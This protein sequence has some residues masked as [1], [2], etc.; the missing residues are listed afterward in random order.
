MSLAT[1][2]SASILS[3]ELSATMNYP[4]KSALHSDQFPWRL[5]SN[6][7]H[8]NVDTIH[9]FEKMMKPMTI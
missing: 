7:I 9:G 3:Y 4:I 6:R 5:P 2:A 8:S 1:Y